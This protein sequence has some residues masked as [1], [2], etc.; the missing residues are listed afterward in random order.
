M[1]TRD[2]GITLPT[3]AKV[4]FTGGYF[5]VSSSS[6]F[7]SNASYKYSYDGISPITQVAPVTAAPQAI[8]IKAQDSNAGFAALGASVNLTPG[9]GS[10]GNKSGNV[11]IK[12]SAGIGSAWNQTHI[13]LGAYHLWVDSSSRLRIKGSA[14]ANETDG[15]VVGLDLSASTTYDP[16]NLVDAAGVTTTVTVAGAAL[17]DF[18]IASFNKDLQGI[19]VTAYVSAANTV[20]VSFQNESGGAVDLASGTLAVKI[21]KA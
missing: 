16:P 19:T 5:E 6:D 10:V 20:S 9:Q 11:V 15:S 2:K 4:R 8:T 18:A 1:T 3:W 17:G 14:P 12:D 7:S 13:E 21:I